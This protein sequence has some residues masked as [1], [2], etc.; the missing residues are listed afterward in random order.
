[1]WSKA[2]IAAVGLAGTLGVGGAAAH[3]TSG[4]PAKAES[5]GLLARADHGTLEVKQKGQWV[6]Y[7]LDRGNV[8]A[9][10]PTSITLSRPDGQSVTETIDSGTK[11]KGVTSE[12]GIQTGRSALVLSENGTAVRIRQV[13]T[14]R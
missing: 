5:R 1:M 2:V 14:P 7:Q 10:S 3:A 4:H 13:T 12:A 6:T 9:V 8:T 11:Y